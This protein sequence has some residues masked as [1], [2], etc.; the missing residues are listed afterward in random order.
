MR[1]SHEHTTGNS[2]D[3]DPGTAC[4]KTLQEKT[5]KYEKA[6]GA[7]VSRHSQAV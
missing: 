7:A 5:K 3:D 6:A 2:D 1:Q 4:Q